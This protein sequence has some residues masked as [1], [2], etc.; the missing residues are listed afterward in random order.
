MPFH[1]KTN[2][3]NMQK[4]TLKQDPHN[5][6]TVGVAARLGDLVG[7]QKMVWHGKSFQLKC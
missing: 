1:K 4:D 3:I 5:Y 7:L 6:A 2:S